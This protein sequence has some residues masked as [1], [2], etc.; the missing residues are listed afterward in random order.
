MTETASTLE[1]RPHPPELKD[2]LEAELPRRRFIEQGQT[3]LA[4][5]AQW[6]RENNHRLGG[7]QAL[8]RFTRAHDDLLETAYAHAVHHWRVEHGERPPAVALVALGGYGRK[9]LFLGSDIDLLFLMQQAGPATEAF[10]KPLIHLLIDLKLNLGYATRTTAECEARVGLDLESTTAMIESRRLAGDKKLFDRY[11]QTIQAALAGRGR[12]WFLRAVYQQW[13]ARHEKYQSTI[14]LLEPNLKEGAGGLRDIHTVLWTL[15]TLCGSVDLRRLKDHARF[16]D[17]DLRRYREAIILLQVVRNEL[18]IASG[19]KVDQLSFAYQP[20]IAARLGYR[21]DDFRL[22]EESLMGAYYH[23]ARVIARLS[24]RAFLTMIGQGKSFLGDLVGTLRRKRLD[25]HH[26]VQDNA[27]FVDP[28]DPGYLTEDP[29]RIMAL[30]ERAARGGYRLGDETLEFIERLAPTLGPAF[31]L[32]PSNSRRFMRILKGPGNVARTLAAM[33]E[34]GVLGRFMPEFEHLRSMVRIDHYHHYT[35]D[36]HSIK[37]LEMAEALLREPVRRR[38]LA[39]QVAARIERWDLLNLALLLHDIGKGYG[40]GHALRG[41]QIAQ[42]VGDRLGLK[43]ADVELVRFLVLSHLKLTHASQRRDLADLNVAR[44]LAK[45]I[46]DLERLKLLYVHSVCDLKAVSP[47]AWNEWKE[48]LLAECYVRTAEVLGESR[49]ESQLPVH[50]ISALRPR[51]L[52][53]V[54]ESPAIANA[55]QKDLGRELDHFLEHASDRY[56]QMTAPAGIARHFL[57]RRTLDEG[58]AIARPP[59]QPGAGETGTGRFTGLS[60]CATDVPGL[61]SYVCGALASKDINIWSAQIFSSTDGFAIN[62][63]QVTDLENRPLPPGLQLERLRQD[64]NQVILGRKSIE[65]LIEKH[66]GRPRKR[67]SRH[68]PLPSR[69]IFDNELSEDYTIIEVR[70]TDRPGLL[71]RITRAISACLLNIQRAFIATEAYGVVDVFYVTDLEFNKIYDP[72]QRKEIEQRLLE[73][74]ST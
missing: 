7:Q 70:T 5:V 21:G 73:A 43:P 69:V 8:A 57:M 40:R 25:A 9:E 2:Y 42:R 18:H 24:R 31:R 15:F 19:G 68:S 62:Q 60:V 55:D 54:R 12:K 44:Q 14:Y 28:R 36:E 13:H 17:E 71:F 53:E 10:L 34:C 58:N 1:H 47:E 64:L 29:N 27:L 59:H 74:V 41:G 63:F 30:F 67:P 39:A 33:H 48:Q 49:L 35:V 51:V 65:E 56:L 72:G 23:N 66:R 46:G 11:W 50:E 38:S 16:A 52:A 22:P 37:T 3:Y 26:F 4:D 6:L 20:T 32:D 45:E 61:F